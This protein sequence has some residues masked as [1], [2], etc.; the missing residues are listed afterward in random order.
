LDGKYT[1]FGELVEGLEAATAIAAVPR[2]E[3]SGSDRPFD[4]PVL[5]SL[6]VV[7]SRP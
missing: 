1:I 7:D 3:K 6:R 2:D 4:P 5:K